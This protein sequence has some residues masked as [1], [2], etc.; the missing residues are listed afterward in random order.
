MQKKQEIQ[1]D[2]VIASYDLPLNIR[3]KD[4]IINS[5]LHKY[6]EYDLMI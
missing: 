5:L 1:V 2:T 6:K 3:N 4:Q